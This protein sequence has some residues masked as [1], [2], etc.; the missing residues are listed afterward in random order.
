MLQAAFDNP[1]LMIVATGLAVI[2]T[3]VGATLDR[4]NLE[5][6]S[7]QAVSDLRI[8]GIPIESAQGVSAFRERF[9][10]VPDVTA[11]AVG[12]RKTG[13]FGATGRGRRFTLLALECL[14]SCDTA[15]VALVNDDLHENLTIDK[16][17][18]IIDGLRD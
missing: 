3:T 6:I 4:S 7:H 2:A 18:Q 11:V 12:M 14:G 9:S 15:P 10:D 1:G 16:I 13:S 17:D 5:R 8:A